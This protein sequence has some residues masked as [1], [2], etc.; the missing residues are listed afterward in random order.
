LLWVLGL[1]AAGK[2]QQAKGKGY[3]H[4]NFFSKVSTNANSS[5]YILITGSSFYAGNNATD[6]NRVC[7]QTT[8]GLT[9]LLIYL[10]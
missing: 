8:A 1:Y 9:A 6:G 3:S 2:H 4:S 7:R 5:Y 10:A